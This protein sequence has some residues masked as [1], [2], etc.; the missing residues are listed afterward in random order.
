MPVAR[1]GAF[2]AI[3]RGRLREEGG[4]LPAARA[5]RERW[6]QARVV[7]CEG[8]EKGVRRAAAAA[9]AGDAASGGKA[10]GKATYAA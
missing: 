1:N 7:H 9:T 10:K 3:A 2:A 6:Q 4:K 8:G 5:A